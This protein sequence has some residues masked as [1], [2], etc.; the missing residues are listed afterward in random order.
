M[1]KREEGDDGDPAGALAGKRRRQRLTL[2]PRP[3]VGCGR[4]ARLTTVH[5][6]LFV[7]LQ[8]SGG[9]QVAADTLSEAGT[10]SDG[11]RSSIASL[12]TVKEFE[13]ATNGSHFWVL[14]DDD[15]SEADSCVD[16][17]LLDGAC[18][19]FRGE[20]RPMADAMQDCAPVAW[21]RR[22]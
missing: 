14:A 11:G 10:W 22:C 19:G 4:G 7:G 21:G 20:P 17:D 8:E 2:A 5:C 16:G 9:V 15:E 1:S 12:S 6:A 18:D 13:Q 3:C